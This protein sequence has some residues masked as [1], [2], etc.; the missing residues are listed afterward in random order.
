MPCT[1]M[2]LIGPWNAPV[3]LSTPARPSIVSRLAFAK[4]YFPVIGVRAGMRNVP[5]PEGAGR[6]D[7][8][9]GNGIGQRRDVRNR[10]IDAERVHHEMMDRED[11]RRLA[12]TLRNERDDGVRRFE[13]I[14]DD[15]AAS[16]RA[17]ASLLGGGL[18]LARVL[19]LVVVAGRNLHLETLQPYLCDASRL[20]HQVARATRES[21]TRRW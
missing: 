12:R 16:F 15:A 20:L 14:D 11:L 18:L 6:F 21:R 9:L 1:S 4:T 17:S 7:L 10:L 2:R 8:A 5:R 19:A 13:S 3:E